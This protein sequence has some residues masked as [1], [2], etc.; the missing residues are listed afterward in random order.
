ME[1]CTPQAKIRAKILN[2]YF[3]SVFTPDRNNDNLPSVDESPYPSISKIDLQASVITKFLQ[4]LDPSKAAGPDNIPA[5]FLEAI[6]LGFIFIL[7][8]VSLKQGVLPICTGKKLQL[9]QFL[10][11][12]HDQTQQ[13]TGQFLSPLY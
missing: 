1:V 9:S 4:D 13:I 3:S 2:G 8:S 10:R 6:C 5:R 7:F 11:R 12:N